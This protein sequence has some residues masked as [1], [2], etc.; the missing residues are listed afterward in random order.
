MIHDSPRIMMILYESA[1]LVTYEVVLPGE[2]PEESRSR[3][4]QEAQQSWRAM[5]QAALKALLL[6]NPLQACQSFGLV[7]S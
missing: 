7:V 3:V 2:T 6:L 5:D 1:L 4:W